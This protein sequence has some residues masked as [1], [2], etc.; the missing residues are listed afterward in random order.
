MISFYSEPGSSFAHEMCPSCCPGFSA[1]AK[2]G[3]EYGREKHIKKWLFLIMFKA[4]IY[5][6][7]TVKRPVNRCQHKKGGYKTKNPKRR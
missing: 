4:F 7:M 5:V 3:R 6:D 2:L 1:G